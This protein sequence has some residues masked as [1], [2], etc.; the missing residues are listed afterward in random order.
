M[1]GKAANKTK[2]R[3]EEISEAGK[4][5]RIGSTTQ[6]IARLE[7]T[8]AAAEAK[9][10]R[11][12]LIPTPVIEID[13]NFTI[14]YINPAGAGIAG[15]TPEEVIG[16]KCYNLFKTPHCGTLECR[17][18]QAMQKD[19]V[20]TG[21]TVADPG[22]LNIPIQ[23]TG[24]ALKDTNGNIIGA[25]EYVID[26]TETRKAMDDARTK[27]DF[28]NKIPAPVMAID[29]EMNTLFINPAGAGM[30]G[31]TPEAC[32]GQKCYSLFNT[33]HCNTPDCQVAKAMQQDGIFTNDT[34]AKLPSGELPIRYTG[35][36]LKD[37]EGN[38]VGGLEYVLDISKE[39]EITCEIRNIVTATAEGR[40][41]T[42]ADVE[43][44]KGNY[45]RIMQGVND[46]LDTLNEVLSQINTVAEQ[47]A[48]AS[49]QISDSS[50]MLSQAA[51]EQASSLE[52][53]TSA[54]NEMG[55]QTKQN[56]ENATQANQ[57]STEVRDAAEKGN[58]Q[59]KEMVT[60]MEK[61]ND[62]SQSISKI[63]KVIDEIAFQTNLLALNA[64]V[65]AAR[66]GKHGKGFAVVAEEVR[67]LAA[68]SAKAAK[69]TAELIEGSVAE[70]RGGMEVADKTAKA[71]AEIV[72]GVSKVTDL[73]GE[74]AAASNEQAQGIIQINQ[75]LSQID[76]VTQQNMSSAEETASAAEEL[77]SQAALL[78][79]MVSKFKLAQAK[80]VVNQTGDQTLT[81][82]MF[83]MLQEMMQKQG[84]TFATPA[85]GGPNTPHQT[86][87]ADQP[88]S[89]IAL[90]D[91]DFG[92]F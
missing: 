2:K 52:E 81:P 21:E 64:A 62:S 72:N 44:F 18:G 27:V 71:L 41:D 84:R 90:D 53:I 51:T 36:P 30:V 86:R 38:I 76:Q 5:S 85:W 24:T 88:P 11:L 33:R 1:T 70:V 10:A 83:Q 73:V 20:F 60:A 80:A 31:R 74:I 65:E 13:K 7:D 32:I 61:I 28:L 4:A 43:R 45:R 3:S 66:A 15:K 59:M 75:G 22:G 63:I 19:G 77:S 17:C 8:L 92:K 26:I 9:A 34:V 78:R 37:A 35:A 55:S 14:T 42:R 54:M 40:L 12:D 39:I 46:I 47:V 6:E 23:Y 50:Q 48:S 25:L 56:A 79:E 68:R 16:M 69:E 58:D 29:K 49:R 57:L 91:K 87:M 89:V 67:N 82:E